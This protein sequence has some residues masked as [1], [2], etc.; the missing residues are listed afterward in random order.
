[1]MTCKGCGKMYKGS[2]CKCG[3]AMERPNLMKKGEHSSSESASETTSEHGEQEVRMSLQQLHSV[4]EAATKLKG[5][6]KKETLVPAWVQSLLTVA[7]ENLEHIEGYFESKHVKKGMPANPRMGAGGMRKIANKP[8]KVKVGT[9]GH[10]GSALIHRSED[11]VASDTKKSETPEVPSFPRVT[12]NPRVLLEHF[13]SGA[14]AVTDT[15]KPHSYSLAAA[16]THEAVGL[17]RR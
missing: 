11:A 9:E 14:Q 3:Y 6:V 13:A 16:N 7:H 8:A 1:M 5:H 15:H 4:C 12:G 17:R 2:M 10:V